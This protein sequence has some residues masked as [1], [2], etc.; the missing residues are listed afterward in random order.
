MFRL[1]IFKIIRILC[2]NSCFINFKHRLFLHLLFFKDFWVMRIGRWFL[3]LLYNII[4]HSW[5]ILWTE[6]KWIFFQWCRKVK[7]KKFGRFF[8]R[9]ENR[10]NICFSQTLNL[11][12]IHCHG[13]RTFSFLFPNSVL[14][15][16]FHSFTVPHHLWVNL[17]KRRGTRPS[18]SRLTLN[19]FEPPAPCRRQDEKRHSCR[20]CHSHRCRR[21]WPLFSIAQFAKLRW[22]LIK[23]TSFTS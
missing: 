11:R 8:G 3:Y 21:H 18:K 20:P 16:S 22:S 10:T 23:V 2:N 9:S 17:R 14:T 19:D 15:V 7:I 13:I 4:Y 5:F 12:S 1:Y 6:N